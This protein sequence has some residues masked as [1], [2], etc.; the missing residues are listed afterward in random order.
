MR[1]FPLWKE[2]ARLQFIAEAFNLFNHTNIS[3]VAETALNGTALGSG[4]CTVAVA[5]GT[6]GTTV[7]ALCEICVLEMSF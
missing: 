1:E 5:G 2:K 6:N 7:A 4:P 3:S